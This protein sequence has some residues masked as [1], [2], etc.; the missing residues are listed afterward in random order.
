M[1]GSSCET[2][3]WYD[4]TILKHNN[5]TMLDH[6]PCSHI[7]SRGSHR[8]LDYLCHTCLSWPR[9]WANQNSALILET[10]SPC[11]PL[12]NW[13]RCLGSET[14]LNEY[15]R[16]TSTN[17]QNDATALKHQISPGFLG[18][19][20]IRPGW[21]YWSDSKKREVERW[22][23]WHLGHCWSLGTEV[24]SGSYHWWQ[25][26]SGFPYTWNGS[27]AVVYL[28]D[29]YGI[30]GPWSQFI[31]FGPEE[32]ELDSSCLQLRW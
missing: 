31:V 23:W 25:A 4:I 16:L 32:C 8:R 1:A 14:E 26:H 15:S 29:R 6:T 27:S 13:N 7:C 11:P 5:G 3:S 12:L 10:T 28:A 21:L 9:S 18:S 17:L 2:W 24:G 30:F 19:S 22:W 20:T